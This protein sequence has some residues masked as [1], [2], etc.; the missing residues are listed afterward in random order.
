ML[1]W[2][3]TLRIII[4]NLNRMHTQTHERHTHTANV[5]TNDSHTQMKHNGFDVCLD[6]Q[7]SL[8]DIRFSLESSNRMPYDIEYKLAWILSELYF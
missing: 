1:C 7:A 5:T 2:S 4:R 8:K 6:W 3:S